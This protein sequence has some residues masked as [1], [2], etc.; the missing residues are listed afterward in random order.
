MDTKFK[1]CSISGCKRNAH[2]LEKGSRG[3]CQHHYGRWKRHGDPLGGRGYGSSPGE[4]MRWLLETA[5]QYTGDDCLIWPFARW[6]EGYA[7]VR[8]GRSYRYASRVLCEKVHGE[9]PT[10]GHQ[11]AHSCGK[12][13]EGCINPN[14]LSW[15]TVSENQMDRIKHG[16]S[17]RG[18]RNN[19]TTLTRYEVLQIRKMA[20]AG[21]PHSII[22]KRFEIARSSVNRHANRKTWSWLEG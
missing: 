22:A 7:K 8:E 3:F 9:P 5:S 13:H 18:E 17:N 15:K 12:G 4:P 1:P 2:Y 11:A 14:H 20:D 6:K 21:I 10:P 19:Q 16:T